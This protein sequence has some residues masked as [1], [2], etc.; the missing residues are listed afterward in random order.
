MNH[1]AEERANHLIALFTFVVCESEIDTKKTRK[2]CALVVVHEL[3]KDLDIKSRDF[4]FWLNVKH[5]IEEI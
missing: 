5:K 4:V 2:G 1:N 3:M